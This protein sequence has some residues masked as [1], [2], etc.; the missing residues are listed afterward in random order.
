[1]ASHSFTIVTLIDPDRSLESWVILTFDTEGSISSPVR[2][3]D[4]P[5]A[6][7]NGRR[8]LNEEGLATLIRAS[9]RPLENH[10]VWAMALE[11]NRVGKTYAGKRG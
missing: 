3:S 10:S 7:V 4:I 11:L 8:V 6:I 2:T 9:E 1:M 5:S